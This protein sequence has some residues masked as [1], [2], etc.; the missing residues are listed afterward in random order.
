MKARLENL[1]MEILLLECRGT[2]LTE[3]R[4]EGSKLDSRNRETVSKKK[5]R[6]EMNS[7][8]N[9][10]DEPEGCGIVVLWLLGLVLH[11]PRQ[12]T[13]QGLHAHESLFLLIP[14]V[15]N[16]KFMRN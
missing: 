3:E 2:N 16:K 13:K 7:T 5:N 11:V 1:S 6:A 9:Q 12:K 8:S 10:G 15:Q 4:G 14:L